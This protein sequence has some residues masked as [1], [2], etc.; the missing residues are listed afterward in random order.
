MALVPRTTQINDVV[1]V[2]AG[3]RV[4]FVLRPM[5]NNFKAIGP[6]YING[7]MYGQAFVGEESELQDITLR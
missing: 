6:C 3:A 5:D 1:A 7:I 4:P 2:L